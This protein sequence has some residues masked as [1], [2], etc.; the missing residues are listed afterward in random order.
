MRPK[1]KGS[2]VNTRTTF[3]YTFMFNPMPITAAT[4]WTFDEKVIPGRSHPHRS[5]G[6]GSGEQISFTLYLDG[7]RGLLEVSSY[8]RS[9]AIPEN[10]LLNV[11]A[12]ID[13]LRAMVRPAD[14]LL[15]NAYGTPD[16]LFL[17]LKAVFTGEGRI[18]ALSTEYTETMDGNVPIKAKCDVTFE[19]TR[20]SNQS[21]DN[22]VNGNGNDVLLPVL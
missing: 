11:Q 9:G 4:G 13:E 5:G 2:L 7:S 15:L 6:S 14:P 17:D 3:E 16:T 20:R 8:P 18:T 21:H 22:L 1:W 19:A 10:R 12:W